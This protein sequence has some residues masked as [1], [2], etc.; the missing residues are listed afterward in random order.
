MAVPAGAIKR[1][2]HLEAR[3]A[4]DEGTDA[5]DGHGRRQRRDER[6]DHDKPAAGNATINPV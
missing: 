2:G 1:A 3:D 6:C 4:A 5:L